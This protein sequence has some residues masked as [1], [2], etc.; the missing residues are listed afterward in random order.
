MQLE[1]ETIRGILEKNRLLSLATMGG[2]YPDNSV[3]CFAY[4][5]DF[6]LYFGAYS[7]TLKCRNIAGNQHVAVTVGTLQVHG[8]AR[9]VPYGSG[10][11]AEKR[12]IYDKRF[13]QY[14][15]VFERE[16]NELYEIEPLVVWNYNTKRGEMNR[17][18]MVIDEEYYRDIQPYKFHTYTDR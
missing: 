6:R 15:E 4:D 18:E 16:G 8:R 11:Y 13:P 2:A 7:D 5:G 1:P 3:V 17:D 10:E 14:K 9:I 12:E